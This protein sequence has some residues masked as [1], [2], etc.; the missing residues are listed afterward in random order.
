MKK[1]NSI[2]KKLIDS[3]SVNVYKN[4]CRYIG[5]LV[6]QLMLV[7]NPNLICGQTNAMHW[8][9]LFNGNNLDGWTQIGTTGNI[10]VVHS[11]ITCN[12][13]KETNKH[14]YLVTNQKYSDFILEMDVKTD[15][16][17]NSGIILRSQ[18]AP[19]NCDTCHTTIYGYQVKLDSRLERRWTGGIFYDY[20][21]TWHWLYSLEED[22]RAR[23][24]FIPG[25]WNHFRMEAL[26]RSVKVW[27]NGIPVTNMLNDDLK[28]GYIALKIHWLLQN[29]PEKEKL[30]GQFKNIK[31]ITENVDKYATS[32]D[33][34]A[35]EVR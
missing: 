17:Y 5:F 33:I 25:K 32:M 20:G 35:K 12:M 15:S 8:K 9:S 22:E 30:K 4:C 7:L 34:P 3:C 24:A 18:K 29:D 23:N 2:L 10:K 13:I 1:V 11:A 16:I 31:I 21:K 14:T 27:I 19:E 28:E 26:G 6:F